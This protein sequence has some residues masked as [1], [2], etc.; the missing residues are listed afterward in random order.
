MRLP[1]GIAACVR[2]AVD[3]VERKP[4]SVKG[5]GYRHM[6]TAVSVIKAVMRSGTTVLLSKVL[7][8]SDSECV[9]TVPDI[10]ERSGNS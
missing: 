2:E 1:T 5:T 8:R 9:S 4:N 7:F 3:R 10:L 6:D